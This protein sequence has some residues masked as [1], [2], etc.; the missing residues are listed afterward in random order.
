MTFPDAMPL[1]LT[2]SRR[3]NTGTAGA[4][5]QILGTENS[6]EFRVGPE[7]RPTEAMDRATGFTSL[8]LPALLPATPEAA[9]T[10]DTTLAVLTELVDI[11]ARHRAS[12]DLSG[13]VSYD[14]SHVLITVGDM[15]Q[16]LPEPEEEPGLFLVHRLT[17]D[18]GQYRGDEAGYTTWA[19]I[20]AAWAPS[21]FV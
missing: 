16:R 11:T 9:S 10:V 21:S 5:A 7:C 8:V 3:P 12:V 13:R 14:G 18:I 20:P 19:S 6:L 1:L 2:P 15:D 17:D 4:A